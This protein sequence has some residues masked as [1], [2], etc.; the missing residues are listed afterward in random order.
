MTSEGPPGTAQLAAAA[1]L[2]AAGV[3]QVVARGP[4]GGGGNLNTTHTGLPLAA[5][6]C[7]SVLGTFVWASFLISLFLFYFPFQHKVGQE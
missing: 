6:H 4:A 5:G 1:L 3:A 7:W 2:G